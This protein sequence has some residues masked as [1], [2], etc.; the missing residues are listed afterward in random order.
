MADLKNYKN[1]F[2]RPWQKTS[3]KLMIKKKKRTKFGLAKIFRKKKSKAI[4]Y[5]LESSSLSDMNAAKDWNT[6]LLDFHWKFYSELSYQRNQNIEK[7]KQALNLAAVS[8]FEFK[9]WQRAV[10]YKYSLHPLCT[11]GS[12][13]FIGG[14]FNSGKEINSQLPEFPCL[15]ITED[16]TTALQ[17]T[18]GQVASKNS[19]LSPIELALTNNDSQTMV[20]ISGRLDKVI[21]S[22]KAKNLHLLVKIFKTFK[23]SKELMKLAK[24][25]NAED[26][27]LIANDK[28]LL[29]SIL[30]QNWRDKPVNFD[31]PSNSQIFGYLVYL[32]G[33]DA[34]IY[35][36]KMTGKNCLAIYVRNFEKGES[37]VHLDDDVPDPKVPNRI[38]S[39]CWRLSELDINEI[40]NNSE[41]TH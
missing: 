14:R 12:I 31:I 37:F 19:K 40:N 9:N 35:P 2:K 20:S 13:S 29:D 16:K 41:M 27:K 11:L 24:Q 1:S 33:V 18:L 21:D 32:S 28:A 17:E 3:V 10:K 6:K 36:S 34:I 22:R 15:Y 8:N 23:I 30:E 38:D 4:A 5:L 39:S 7:I 25:I 26:P